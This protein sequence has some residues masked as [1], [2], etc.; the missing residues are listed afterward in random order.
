MKF[1]VWI[2]LSLVY[3]ATGTLIGCN[4]KSKSA[5]PPPPP[6]P[7]GQVAT[8]AGCSLPGY[9]VPPV[10]YIPPTGIY[11]LTQYYASKTDFLNPTDSFQLDS[12]YSKFLKNVL[13][14]CD[15]CSSTA[16]QAS[17][18]SWMSGFNM[19]MLNLSSNAAT[20]HQMAFYSTPQVS[21]SYFQFAWQFPKI[22]DFFISMFTGIPA[23]SC[24]QGQ[25]SPYWA[26]SVLYETYNSGN[27]FVL[28]VNNGPFYS[29]WNLHKFK[30]YVPVGKIG[31]TSF[32]FQLTVEDKD[33]NIYNLGTG[34]LSRCQTINCR[35][36]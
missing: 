8:P 4:N 31:D 10:G 1:R 23:P 27:G 16:G 5:A 35:M 29:P 12:N 26:T 17:C 11:G 32:A 6:C 9:V 34:T 21:Q 24:T 18:S 7:I 36:F 30:L 2:L 19:L 14:V 28:Y 15:R 20:N 33:H 25:F 22:E 13:G 3:L